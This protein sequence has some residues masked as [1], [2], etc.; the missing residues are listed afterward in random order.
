MI[1][2]KGSL[3]QQ[4]VL[5]WSGGRS[6][7][8][9]LETHSCF[10]TQGVIFAFLKWYH[11]VYIR[12]EAFELILESEDDGMSGAESFFTDAELAY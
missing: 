12:E 7:S 2:N 8:Q 9:T 11:S 3:A 10:S 6:Q 4:G 1:L 5:H